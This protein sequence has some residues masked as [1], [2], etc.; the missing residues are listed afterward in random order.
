M[1]KNKV[2]LMGFYG[3]DK[4]H[5]LSAWT[6]TFEELGID[7]PDTIEDRVDVLFEYIKAHKKREYNNL[8]KMLAS[9][10][11]HT[12]FEKSYIQ[13]YLTVEQASHI[14][15]LKHRI[16]VSIN[17]ES[18]RYKELKEDKFLLPEDW[19][20]YGEVGKKWFLKLQSLS[21]QTN[22]A[23]HDALRELKDAGMSAKRAKESSRFFKMMNSQLE[24]DVS[25][26]FRS[27]M[28]FQKLRNSIHAQDEIE[29]IAQEMLRQVKQIPGN[30]FRYSLEAFNY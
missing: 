9:N 14:H 17:G 23:Y 16:G 30:P 12:P 1:S 22:E 26:N 20:E 19:L 4:H 15:M 13:F 5:S 18:A 24:L 2:T 28:H 21:E 29:S 10:E 25:F 27:F 6:S 8:L 3:G 7:I 11:H